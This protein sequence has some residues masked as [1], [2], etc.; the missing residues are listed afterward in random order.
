MQTLS[1]AYS[2]FVFNC[3]RL[4]TG[5]E[6][7]TACSGDVNG[8]GSINVGKDSDIVLVE[9][10]PLEDISAIRN[11]T[12]VMKGNTAYKPDELYKAV[13]VKPFVASEVL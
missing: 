11:A 4:G 10:N 2:F 1:F 3:Y 5:I 9:G 13:G 8:T 7:L 6:Y 12:L